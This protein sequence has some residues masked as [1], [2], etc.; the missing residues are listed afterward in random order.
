MAKS[1]ALYSF[2]GFKS[3]ARSSTKD[4][5]FRHLTKAVKVTSV[6]K[7]RKLAK[8]SPENE[9]L[10]FDPDVLDA[11]NLSNRRAS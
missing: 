6:E 10:E 4:A 9:Q 1:K 2:L 5:F 8:H 11:G 3:E 7:I